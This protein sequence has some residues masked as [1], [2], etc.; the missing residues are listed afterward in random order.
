MRKRLVPTFVLLLCA[1]LFF[2]GCAGK[3]APAQPPGPQTL[4]LY[5]WADNFEPSVIADFEKK[6]NCKVNYDVFASNEELLAKIQAGGG[7]YDVIQ[8]S[9]Y[10][11]AAMIKLNLLEK[12]D[13]RNMP[14]LK[15]I[16]P[17]FAKVP[18]DPAG[19]YSSVYSWGI[20]GIAYNK[21]FVKEPPTGWA[22]F[23][24]PKY[25]GRVVLF[26]DSREVIGM[27]LKKNG[28]SNSAQAPAQ[29]EKAFQDLKK[30]APNVLAYDSENIKQKF[31]AEEAWIGMMWSSYAALTQTEN[32]N[33]EFIAA[34]E[35][36][37]IWADTLAIP[38]NAKNKALAEKFIN[39]IYEPKV[40]AK[41]FEALG[42]IDPNAKAYELHS[43]GYK[44]NHI[45]K[46]TKDA[47]KDS[48]WL[49]DVGQALTLYDKYW[50]ELKSVK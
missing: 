16:D 41:N 39:Y 5:S 36:G 4:N 12:F 50:T 19:E 13:K 42:Y 8:P 10:M 9:D 28:Y 3:S 2:S 47:L 6:F 11:V 15:N 46:I 31:V 29:L 35:H 24:L 18:Y 32:P 30:L 43:A 7:Q 17:E 38:K 21:K 34:K 14:N 48:E 1:A 26:D 49:A 23:W 20:T 22:D 40:S 33:V 45:F 25:K 27:A 44:N 37:L